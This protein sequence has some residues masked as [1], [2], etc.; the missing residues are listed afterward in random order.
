MLGAA[1]L[2]RLA[3]LVSGAAG[4]LF[5]FVISQKLLFL[6]LHANGLDVW[7]HGLEGEKNLGSGGLRGGWCDMLILLGAGSTAR[8]RGSFTACLIGG[9]WDEILF[10]E[11]LNGR[12]PTLL[13]APC[14]PPLAANTTGK[15]FFEIMSCLLNSAIVCDMIDLTGMVVDK[16][17]SCTGGK[18]LETGLSGLTSDLL[19]IA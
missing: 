5:V 17:S 3:A 8:G 13:A 16:F 19:V 7:G 14:S 10:E 11:C 15:A 9:S 4:G 12:R 6:V 2:S 1:T 18:V